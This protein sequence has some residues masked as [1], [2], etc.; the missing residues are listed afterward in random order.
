MRA[1]EKGYDARRDAWASKD[2]KCDRKKCMVE[3]VDR[4]IIRSYVNDDR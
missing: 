2:T 4:L 1:Y 3:S